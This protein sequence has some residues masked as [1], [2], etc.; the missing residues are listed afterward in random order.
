MKK[1]VLY[2]LSILMIALT[3]CSSKDE[4]SP[5]EIQGIWFNADEG[6]Y[7]YLNVGEFEQYTPSTNSVIRGISYTATSS[8]ITV[9]NEASTYTLSG[10]SITLTSPDRE[11]SVLTKYTTTEWHILT[12]GASANIPADIDDDNNSGSNNDDT[13]NGNSGSGSNNDNSSNNSILGI[14]YNAENNEYMY[15]GKNTVQ[16]YFETSLTL[17]PEL[18][19]TKTNTTINIAGATGT[20][21][22]NSSNISITNSEG[23]VTEGVRYTASDWSTLTSEATNYGGSEYDPTTDGPDDPTLPIDGGSTSN[24]STGNNEYAETFK[25]ACKQGQAGFPTAA[26]D[27]MYEK[28]IEYNITSELERDASLEFNLTSVNCI[29]ATQ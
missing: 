11:V 19:Y 15:V 28:L 16:S 1:H 29:L 23:E 9:N 13:N 18:P 21:V 2:F 17:S 4:V 5:E 26:C 8:T 24:P 3:S 25:A 27:C 7:I 14:W 20:Y 10:N 6:T 22:V 12:A